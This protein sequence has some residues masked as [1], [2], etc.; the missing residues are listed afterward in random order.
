MLARSTYHKTPTSSNGTTV[1]GYLV[2]IINTSDYSPFGVQLDGRTVSEGRY[3][4]GYNGMEKDDE[5]KGEGNSYDFGAR[6]YDSR[7]GRWLSVD[8]LELRFCYEAPYVFSGNSPILYNDKG[9]KYKVPK[10][11][12]ESYPLFTMIIQ[13]LGNIIESDEVLQQNLMY[14][15]HYSDLADMLEVYGNDTGPIAIAQNYGTAY[16]ATDFVRYI[17][18]GYPSDVEPLENTTTNDLL[19]M[20]SKRTVKRMEKVY[21]KLMDPELVDTKKRAKFMSKL[22]SEIFHVVTTLLH[23]GVHVGDALENGYFSN[24]DIEGNDYSNANSNEPYKELGAAALEASGYT[25]GA[26]TDAA[27]QKTIDRVVAFI[28]ESM[29]LDNSGEIINVEE[30]SP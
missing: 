4:Y 29:N 9:G 10:N 18:Y 1:N 24:K 20:V 13:N 22:E 3:R 5:V 16:G 8:P 17:D 12:K 25:V 7:V 19:V 27:S 28:L 23:E 15:G 21:K 2:G 6:I 14:Y 11:V 30:T 26:D